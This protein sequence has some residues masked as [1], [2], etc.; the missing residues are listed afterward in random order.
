VAGKTGTAQVPDFKKGGY[1]FEVINTYIGFAPAENPQFIILLKMDKP[2]GAPLAGLSIVPAFKELAQF[3]LNY[4][5]I[6]P[7]KL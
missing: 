6:P 5:N 3:V 2:K 4:Y 1:T 7:D